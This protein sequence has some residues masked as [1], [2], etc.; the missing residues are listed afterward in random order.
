MSDSEWPWEDVPIRRHSK[1]T[2]PSVAPAVVQPKRR[3]WVL[4]QALTVPTEQG[5]Y[6]LMAARG[7]GGV[8]RGAPE[9]EHD[10]SDDQD[11]GS[12]AQHV[13]LQARGAAADRQVVP[14]PSP[15]PTC[16]LQLVTRDL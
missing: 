11:T 1:D 3:R 12:S 5:D 15:R 8:R 10:P 2:P 16:N 6:V 13:V 4:G 14:Q 7:N 9:N